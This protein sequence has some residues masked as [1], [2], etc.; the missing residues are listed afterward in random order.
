M[1]IR[2]LFLA[3][4]LLVCLHQNT[5]ARESADNGFIT[6]QHQFIMRLFLEKRYFDCI[7]ETC[8][9]LS[10]EKSAGHRNAAFYASLIGAS[11]YCGGQYKSAITA[12][13]KNAPSEGPMRT[14]TAIL[15]ASSYRQLGMSGS[16]GQADLIPYEGQPESAQK[17]LLFRQIEIHAALHDYEGA[18]LRMKEFKKYSSADIGVLSRKSQNTAG[19]D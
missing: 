11:Y 13:Q 19:L 7:G 9:M 17:N 8:R 10:Y 12:I 4:A 3:T 1:R 15:L 2:H 16:T 18:L 6:R 5:H 14:Y